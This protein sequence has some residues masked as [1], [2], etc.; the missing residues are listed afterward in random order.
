[1]VVTFG[2]RSRPIGQCGDDGTS[3]TEDRMVLCVSVSSVQ[4]AI[5]HATSTAT[6]AGRWRAGD[7]AYLENVEVVV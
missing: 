7:C 5:D 4:Q 3:R 6:S 1:M 2:R